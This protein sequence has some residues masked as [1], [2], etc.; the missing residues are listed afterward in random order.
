[1]LARQLYREILTV[2]NLKLRI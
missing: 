1:M 2:F